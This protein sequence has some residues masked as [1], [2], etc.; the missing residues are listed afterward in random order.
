MSREREIQGHALRELQAA[1]VNV[2]PQ[3]CLTKLKG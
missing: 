1:R 3:P 2:F